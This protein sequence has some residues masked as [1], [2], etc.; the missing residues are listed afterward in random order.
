MEPWEESL[1]GRGVRSVEPWRVLPLSGD[2]KLVE[3][4][5]LI[6]SGER[7]NLQLHYGSSPE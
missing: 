7:E 4:S 2:I 3:T 1:A 5:V 6:K